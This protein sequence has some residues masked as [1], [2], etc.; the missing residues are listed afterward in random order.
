META[1]RGEQPRQYSTPTEAVWDC[2]LIGANTKLVA[3]QLVKHWPEMTPSQGKIAQKCGISVRTVQACIAE[4]QEK[5]IISTVRVPGSRSTYNFVGVSIPRL[6]D[7]G[8]RPPEPPQLPRDTPADSAGVTYADSSGV[9]PQIL[10][11]SISASPLS[12]DLRSPEGGGARER[13]RN[14]RPRSLSSTKKID[15]PKCSCCSSRQGLEHPLEGWVLPDELRA[16]LVSRGLSPQRIAFRMENLLN[17][18]H[19][20]QGRRCLSVYVREQAEKWLRWELEDSL[21]C[22]NADS[23]HGNAP[24]IDF[25]S[26]LVKRVGGWTPAA[27]SRSCAA[28]SGLDIVEQ[29]SRFVRSGHPAKLG[30][31]ATWEQDGARA[32]VELVFL[33]SLQHLA[34]QRRR[35]ASDGAAA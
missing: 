8:L 14:P 19:A 12:R 1:V 34:A 13:A 10:R 9:P 21:S 6:G 11:G 18:E 20:G 17:I 3:L 29:Y 2:D 16:E 15:T 5:A 24:P 32:R 25:P 27:P 30:L 26:D 7:R 31:S 33:R 22:L 23:R 28:E 4:L 35:Q